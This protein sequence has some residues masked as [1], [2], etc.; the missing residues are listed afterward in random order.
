MKKILMFAVAWTLPLLFSCNKDKDNDN[1]SSSIPSGGSFDFAATYG[2]TNMWASFNGDNSFVAGKLNSPLMDTK[3]DFSTSLMW[4]TYTYE[5][6]TYTMLI[7]N[8]TDLWGTLKVLGGDQVEVNIPGKEGYQ[9]T[10]TVQITKPSVN[11]S[12]RA[13]NHTWK[14]E[15]L[16]LVYRGMTYNSTNGVV[17]LNA[18]EDW[19]LKNKLIDKKILEDNMVMQK[20]IFTDSKCFILF[21]NTEELV[22]EI[23]TSDLANFTMDGITGSSAWVPFLEGQASIGFTN[24]KC[25]FS[26]AGKYQDEPAS[27]ILTLGL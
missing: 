22:S 15:S 26:V 1:G 24:G 27:A 7:K 4:G 20:V 18:F 13:A 9:G 19:A 12:Q 23:T 14:P 3:A 6:G 16:T 10:I 11:D 5:N 2:N 25:V 17:D 8:T 21:A